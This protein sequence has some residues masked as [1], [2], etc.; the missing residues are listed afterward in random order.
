MLSRTAD[1]ALR[2]VLYLASHE[3]EGPVPAGRIAEALGAPPNYMAKTLQALARAGVVQGLRGPAGGFRLRV[4]AGELS[5]MRV[6]ESFDEP[7]RRTA[8]LM[9]DRTC[10]DA[11]PC[12]AHVSWT[13]IVEHA[14][15]PLR[16]TTVAELLRREANPITPS[17]IQGALS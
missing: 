16:R 3:A 12:A 11:S 14:R 7:A 1:H 10:D 17:S 6:I 2:A 15:E 4:P 9:G 5:L 13:S 8:C